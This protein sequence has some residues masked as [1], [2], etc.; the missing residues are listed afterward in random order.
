MYYY[1]TLSSLKIHVWWKKYL[2]Q[3]QIVQFV[4]DI[5]A[6]ECQK[7][8]IF[9]QETAVYSRNKEPYDSSRKS[10]KFSQKEP[11]VLPRTS[12]IFP[13]KEPYIP[14]GTALYSHNKQP[15]IFARNALHFRKNGNAAHF[16]QKCVAVCYIFICLHIYIYLSIYLY[17]YI[18]IYKYLYNTF[19]RNALHFTITS[20][21][22][23]RRLIGS[24]KLQI[25]FHKRATKYRS[26]LREMTYKDKG[27]YESSSP[28]VV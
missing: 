16:L 15:N 12:P 26:L 20:C 27:S 4:V 25:I 6:C 11:Y 17:I 5:A 21:T 2:T 18:Y 22:G 28:R 7:S 1:Y 9:P 24:P 8:P 3:F 23:W 13:Q 10:P 19:A 14:Q